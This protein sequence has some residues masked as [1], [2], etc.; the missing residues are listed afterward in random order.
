MRIVFAA[1]V[2]ALVGMSSCDSILNRLNALSNEELK[3]FALYAQKIDR[4]NKGI[5]LIFGG[6]EDFVDDLDKPKLIAVILEF[7]KEN[8]ELINV[9]NAAVRPK[10][11]KNATNFSIDK[12]IESLDPNNI[13]ELRNIAIALDEEVRIIHPK[14]GG[15]AETAPRMSAAELIKSI[16]SNALILKSFD[17]KELIEI[18]KDRL[19]F[20]KDIGKISKTKN[21]KKSLRVPV[22]SILDLMRVASIEELRVLAIIADEVTR[23]YN[24][25]RGGIR[26][27]VYEMSREELYQVIIHAYEVY[28][29]DFD[30]NKLDELRITYADAIRFA[31][32][33]HEVAKKSNAHEGVNS[34]EN[35]LKSLDL[36]GLRK[37][38]IALDEYDREINPDRMGG[39]AEF[40]NSLSEPELVKIITNYL[41]QYSGALTVEFMKEL[42]VKYEERSQFADQYSQRTATNNLSRYNKSQLVQIALSL[43]K[44]YRVKK[45][46]NV[47]GGLRDYIRTLD[48]P[49]LI[50]KI[51]E[52]IAEIPEA[53]DIEFIENLIKGEQEINLIEEIRAQPKETL[54][55]IA[56]ALEAFERK[57]T[58]KILFGGIHDNGPNLSEEQIMA[59]IEDILQ[60]FP[61][62]LIP[63][64]LEKVLEEYSN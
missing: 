24:H 21:P 56:T 48:E 4:K 43:E 3:E 36:K 26:E 6:L 33:Y 41:I 7:I 44:Y 32:E 25:K 51:I 54:I 15:V 45:N 39:V 53:N 50:A 38:A 34:I 42:I 17:I 63:G 12:F 20:S 10:L 11:G 2:I 31:E 58:G 57:M 27:H 64:N 13:E 9:A 29:K 60:R 52:M 47:I 1:I 14:V 59:F 46:I 22:S 16:F 40:V 62:L 8:P 18:H 5:D 30:L 23:K 37:L 61:Q 49:Q 55:I 19:Q 35:F 28:P